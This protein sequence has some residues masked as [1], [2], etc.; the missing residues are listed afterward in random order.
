MSVLRSTKGGRYAPPH[1]GFHVLPP[2]CQCV[3]DDSGH[4][5]FLSSLV[6]V[7]LTLASVRTLAATFIADEVVYQPG[8]FR[9]H[10][11]VWSRLQH[12]SGQPHRK[13]S[14]ATVFTPFE[15]LQEIMATFQL[16][17]EANYRHN[18]FTP[19]CGEASLTRS[20][21]LLFTLDIART[22]M[23]VHT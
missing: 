22:N 4:L 1:L 10:L 11:R 23:F 8:K 17:D 5:L 18:T 21:L 6:S 7:R 2:W 9:Q 16:F 14:A 13:T 19:W 20:K 12:S 3:V 15:H